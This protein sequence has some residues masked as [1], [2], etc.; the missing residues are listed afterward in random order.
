MRIYLIT[1]L[2]PLCNG[3]RYAIGLKGRGRAVQTNTN[4][5]ISS[6]RYFKLR[7]VNSEAEFHPTAA[8]S[9]HERSKYYNV[10][11]RNKRA[12]LRHCGAPGWADS[13][14][15]FSEHC[16]L[17]EPTNSTVLLTNGQS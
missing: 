1:V 12:R 15:S 2:V 8:V 17:V 3:V 9:A 7:D 5:A 10:L 4:Q 16:T 11:Q 14:V 13:P 6:D